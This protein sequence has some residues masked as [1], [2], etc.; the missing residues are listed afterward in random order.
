MQQ[1]WQ[2]ADQKSSII[3]S[4][5][6]ADDMSAMPHGPG[7]KLSKHWIKVIP[8]LAAL[9]LLLVYRNTPPDFS[10]TTSAHHFSVSAAANHGHRLQFDSNGLEWSDPVSAFAL[11][12]PR[13][14][15]AHFSLAAESYSGL[16]LK[17]F[18]Y[19]RPPPLA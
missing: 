2:P 8:A 18:H 19:N 15:S 17:G 16:Q 6:M 5:E 9:F 11:F 13:A 7:G 1:K 14:E 12:L 3:I 10:P 4:Q